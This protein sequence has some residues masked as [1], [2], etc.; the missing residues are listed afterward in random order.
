M[1]KILGL[2]LVLGGCGL[3]GAAF[4]HSLRQRPIQL[5]NLQSALLMVDSEI[6][7]VADP[8]PEVLARVA[9]RVKE[10][11]SIL[12][13]EAAM[14]LQQAEGSTA[15][16]IWRRTLKVWAP[17]TQL[18]RDDIEVL[19]SVG[20]GLG[21]LGREEQLRHIRLAMEYLRVQEEIADSERDK[22]ERLWQT[23]GF[24]VGLALVILSW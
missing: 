7:Y 3:V 8:L 15:D 23:M 14:G 2:A 9:D 4:A 5:R 20:Q 11:G 12:F 22:Q 19:A 1:V 24:L 13:R 21:S 18:R 16:E 17:G 10:P 6:G